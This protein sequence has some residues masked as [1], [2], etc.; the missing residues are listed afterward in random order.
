MLYSNAMVIDNI[1]IYFLKHVGKLL[2]LVGW[3]F[4]FWFFPVN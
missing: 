2:C 3:V 4:G 1:L